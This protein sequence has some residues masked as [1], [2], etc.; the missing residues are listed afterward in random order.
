MR[1]TVLAVALVI[2]G[3]AAAPV[4]AETTHDPTGLWLTE[5]ERS[6]IRIER[7]EAGLCGRIHWIVD[8]G[9]QYDSKN[10]DPSK[11]DRP[12]CGLKILWGVEQQADAPNAWEDGTVYKANSGDK[13]GLDLTMKGPD[14]LK[15]RGYVGFS[16][17]GK[18]QVWTRVT[19]EQYPRC[20]PPEG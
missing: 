8:G 11:R 13:F 3:G 17:L 16:L 18:S 1:R 7:C 5:N 4:A 19:R 2:A 10:P 20:E 15:L 9:M 6:V 12:M 14:K